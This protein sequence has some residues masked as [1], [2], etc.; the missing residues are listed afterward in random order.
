MAGELQLNEQRLVTVF[1]GFPGI[2]RKSERK[3]PQTGQSFYSLQARYAQREG[4]QIDDPNQDLKI[5]PLALDKVQLI[6]NFVLSM[7]EQ[8]TKEEDRRQ[9]RRSA[10]LANTVAASAAILSSVA[11]IAVALLAHGAGK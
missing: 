11:A 2:F 9:S 10:R 6:M 4:W 1:E 5:G 8:E 3:N 7:V